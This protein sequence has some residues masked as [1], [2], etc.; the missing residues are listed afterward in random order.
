[1]RRVRTAAALFMV[2]LLPGLA[3]AQQSPATQT[4]PTQAPELT[5][6]FKTD[7]LVECHFYLKTYRSRSTE[8]APGSGVDL[9]TEIGIYSRA[10]DTLTTQDVWRWFEE[11]IVA[12]PDPAAVREAASET[13]QA[14]DSPRNRTGL[15]MLLD[16]LESAY[17][18]FLESLW[19]ER[20]RG[21]NRH[22]VPARKHLIE[23]EE[24]IV[25]ALVEKMAFSPIDAPITVLVVV[26]SGGVTSWGKTADGYFTVVGV[27]GLSALSL[28]EMGVH[29]ATHILDAAQP[30]SSGSVL[31]RVKDGLRGEEPASVNAFMHGLITYNAGA[32][33]KQFI[34]RSYLPKGVRAPGQIEEYRPYLSTYEFIWTDYLEGKMTTDGIVAKLLEE[35]QAIRK[36]EESRKKK[37]S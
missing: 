29:E 9:S 28:V 3:L 30:F 36:L 21:I 22:L 12:N 25:E 33:V 27:A 35:F 16:G 15:N 2:A 26:R 10:R 14:Y 23:T 19:A 8:P 17:P 11:L 18:K 5:I 4:A 13:P 37:A 6:R 34:S 31:K 7:P 24:R 32:L 20:L 1:M